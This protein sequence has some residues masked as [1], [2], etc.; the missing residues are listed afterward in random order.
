MIVSIGYPKEATN[1]ANRMHKLSKV[2]ENMV[3]I[4]KSTVF[5]YEIPKTSPFT[6]APKIMKNLGTNLTSYVQY[7]NA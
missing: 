1:K 6:T 3:H 2:T 4:Q 5:L 7:L